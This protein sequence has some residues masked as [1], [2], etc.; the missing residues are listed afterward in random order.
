MEQETREIR[1]P[2]S[3]Q[4]GEREIAIPVTVPVPYDALIALV[5]RHLDGGEEL[6]GMLL[7]YYADHV[8]P[9][10]APDTAAKNGA[11]TRR[12]TP[13]RTETPAAPPADADES[14]DSTGVEAPTPP[15]SRRRRRDE[16]TG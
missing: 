10:A 3:V 7:E 4:V 9:A 8:S 13:R 1:V 15:R 5:Q 6:H 16:F 11:G 2:L 12:R 14:A